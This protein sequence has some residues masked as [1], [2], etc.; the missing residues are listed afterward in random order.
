MNKISVICMAG[1]DNFVDPI[2]AG[3]SN[4]YMV[5]K[6]IVKTEQEIFNAIDYG[7]IIWLEWA[8]QSAVI[9]TNY[10]GI[11]GKKVIVR[12]HSYEVFTDFPKQINWYNVDRLIF[13]APHI[14]EILNELIPHNEF[15][16]KTEIVYNGIDIERYC[17]QKREYGYNIAWVGYINYKKNPPMALQILKKL[18]EGMYTAD[19]RYILHIAGSYQD[20]RYKVYLEYMIKEMGLQD[21]VKFHGWLDDMGDFWKDIN[22]LLH[23][24]I[25]EGHS[26]AIMEAM[27]RGIKPIIHDFRGARELYPVHPDEDLVFNTVEEAADKIMVKD[28]NSNK[29]RNWLMKKG[30]TL[31]NQ[32]KGMRRII[33]GI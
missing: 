27:A 29:Y 21:N 31:E 25:H 11:K 8:N 22:Y 10:K 3:L 26:Y 33:E 30:W 28:Y 1:L 23:T 2:I 17:P 5:R 19:Q 12:L 20:L 16:V 6:F 18:T 13:V 15:K 32:L 24:S 9:S 14:R 4:N 7:D